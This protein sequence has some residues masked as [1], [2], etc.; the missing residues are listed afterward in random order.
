[1]GIHFSCSI[2]RMKGSTGQLLLLCFSS[3]SAF[4]LWEDGKEYHFLE[5]SAIHVG[6]NDL[7][8][9]ASGVRMMSD[10]KIQVEGN[11]LVVTI[12]NMQEAHYSHTY[13]RG[14][15]PYRL[16]QEKIK[17][18]NSKYIPSLGYE[19]GNTFSMVL[20]DGL[21]SQM[22]LPQGLSLNGKNMMR[23]LASI[24]QFDTTGHDMETWVKRERS[25]HGDCNMLYTFTRGDHEQKEISKTVSH[26]KDC[27][28]RNFKLFDNSDAQSCAAQGQM[29]NEYEPTHEKH[30]EHHAE[31]I[32]SN[33]MTTLQLVELKPNNFKIKK[34]FSAGAV[35]VQ[36][37]S[38]SG[39]THVTLANRTFTL[40]G[41]K[42][43]GT[44][45]SV[46]N[47]KAFNDLE[48][49]WMEGKTEWDAP[50][51]IEDLKRKESFFYNGY[52]LEEPQTD[53]MEALKDNIKKHVDEM[54]HFHDPSK[55]Q[56][57]VIQKLHQHDIQTLL[58]FF[59]SLNDDSL[60]KLKSYY[61]G[62]SSD[63]EIQKS[64]K[65]IFFE[66]LPI[67][68]T[69]P[70][71]L[72]VKDI[73][74]DNDLQSD[75]DTARLLTSVPFHVEPVKALA[76]EFFKLVKSDLPHLQLPFTKSAVDLSYAHMVKRT[77]MN[78]MAQEKCFND[79]HTDEFIKRFEALS[80]D[81][82]AK[83]QHFM[84]VFYNLHGSDVLENKLREV[85]F[86]LT[87]KKYDGALRTQAIFALASKALSK[88]AE[89]K[90][91]LPIFLSR[92]ESHEVR[93]AAF[94]IL[95]SGKPTTTVFN[96]IMTYMIYE[97]DYE[98]FN[99][100]YTAFEKFAT[101]THDPCGQERHEF[102]KY[103]IKY[104]NQHMWQ[105]PKYSVG[106]SKTFSNVFTEQKYGYSGSMEVHTIGSYKTASPLSIMVD[107]S[108]QRFHSFNMQVFGTFIRMEGVA[109][110]IVDKIKEFVFNGK[111]DFEK[112][113]QLLFKNMNIR[114]HPNIPAKVDF[115]VMM[116]N[117]VVFEYHLMDTEI[118]SVI[119]NLNKYFNQ[120]TN[121]QDI[122]NFN[123]HFGLTWDMFLY[124]QP[125]DFG[126]PMAYV[127][128]ATSV[129]GLVGEA[130][131]DLGLHGDIDFR[132]DMNTDNT[133]MMMVVHPDQK[134]RYTIQQKRTF[135]HQVRSGL[136]AGLDLSTKKL[137]VA[138]KIPEVETPFS[139][140]AHSHTFLYT[141]NNKITGDQR[142]L[143]KSCPACFMKQI[144]SKNNEFRRNEDLLNSEIHKIGHLYG[145]ELSGKLFDCEMLR[146]FSPG[147][148][149]LSLL[150]P[151]SPLSTETTS[152][153]HIFFS[154]IRQVHSYL[155]F[156]PHIESCGAYFLI[157]KAAVGPVDELV[158]ELDLKQFKYFEHPQQTLGE[159]R[160]NMDGHIIFNGMINRTHHIHLDF[161]AAPMWTKT[162]FDLEIRRAPFMYQSKMY[163]EFPIL[164]HMKTKYFGVGRPLLFKHLKSVTD[165]KVHSSMELQWGNLDQ[166]IRVEGEHKTTAENANNLRNTWY[167]NTC[168]AEHSMEEWRHSDHIPTTDAC[169]FTLHDLM[170]LRHYTWDVT[171][172]NIQPW[173]VTTYKKVGAALKTLL[174][175]F[176]TFIPEYSTHEIAPKQPNI[177][178]EQT[179]HSSRKTFDLNLQVDKEVSKFMD[180][181]Y[182]FNQWTT[183]SYHS[184][185]QFSFLSTSA[186]HPEIMPYLYYNTHC[187]ATSNTIR[188]YDNVTYPYTM[189]HACY[190]LI[191]S[192]CQEHPSFAV[193][194]KKYED[195]KV[196]M[197]AFIGD[198]KVEMIPGNT[199]KIQLK[200][201]DQEYVMKNTG[202][203]HVAEDQTLIPDKTLHK[204]L[205]KIIKN[206]KR[207]SLVFF[208]Q[209][210]LHYDG[211]SLQVIA[212]QH[213]EGQHCGMCGDFNKKTYDEFLNPQMC[214]LRTGEE[215]A[216]AWALD[217]KFCADKV[218]KPACTVQDPV[219]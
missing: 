174:F 64:T 213:L 62:L 56:D 11:K 54:R 178:I 132:L 167:Y 31:P 84:Y 195:T 145:M 219:F 181:S 182:D 9:S 166:K 77:C 147:Q 117:N 149:F 5:E 30:E 143:K 65:D 172:A 193:F 216:R 106:V 205:F 27:V 46:D 89:V 21:V 108:T 66:M 218:V 214:E 202:F 190:T 164:F 201:N 177:R 49:E 96:K 100:I 123:K 59:H 210:V 78:T 138:V 157:S 203:L 136:T 146:H 142:Y 191:S 81:D 48:F 105:K 154:G 17:D 122:F 58:S 197:M 87:P 24:L 175:P 76:E 15:W 170:T 198:Q 51:G 113:K 194:I 44:T 45:H 60:S 153:F 37:F 187:H 101:H 156:F 34:I 126:V 121:I 158:V 39:P 32:H 141:S 85:I 211:H 8:S 47:P 152:I 72:L 171:A 184:L 183:Q 207:F 212:G 114:Q 189:N 41:V 119:N 204:Y 165:Y 12:D 116:R 179:F 159:T 112:L 148:R 16:T 79:L 23:A 133:D 10:V 40:I 2:L 90:Y 125:T 188:T 140:L 110:K 71:A 168:M 169:L 115:V 129:A 150:K 131:K 107:M 139:V 160:M 61:I 42:D 102:A 38:E 209:I 36:R 217:N 109:E 4:T 208:P 52:T 180:V 99:Y 25:I 55:N 93:I 130:R 82:H 155:F 33:S 95:M 6:T 94:D 176:W 86:N 104:W 185:S 14:G 19:A 50:L 215:M 98:V 118:M 144:V 161:V 173:M 162:N 83:L 186:I 192:D 53:I 135:K 111:L 127:S 80:V 70:A 74:M 124:E 7:K 134:I 200:I 199:D 128:G 29:M 28:K 1:M 91:F 206:K 73:V 13:N 97:T 163:H 68:G 196:G 26:F 151:F 3:I 43:K 69:W 20:E 35:I 92:V 137:M 88:G 63:N 18:Q 67:A 57:E 103:F 75:F 22:E 120:L